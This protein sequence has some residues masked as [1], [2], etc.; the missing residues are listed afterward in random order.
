MT[1]DEATQITDFL[2]FA[3]GGCGDCV[4][5]MLVYFFRAFP[6]LDYEGLL[7]R[8]IRDK[9]ITEELAGKVRCVVVLK[10]P[11]GNINKTH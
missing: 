7:L 4:R 9:A 3:H 10:I 5:D 11:P 1:F 6:D 2:S 8:L